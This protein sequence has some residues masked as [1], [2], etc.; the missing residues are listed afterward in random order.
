MRYMNYNRFGQSIHKQF[1]HSW[2]TP[3]IGQNK[4]TTALHTD[5]IRDLSKE[6]CC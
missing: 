2:Q 3:T 5:W 4:L 1:G 6:Q